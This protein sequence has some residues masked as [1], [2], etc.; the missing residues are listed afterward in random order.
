MKVGGRGQWRIERA[1][2]EAYIPQAY[3]ET[4]RELEKRDRT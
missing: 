3:D 2:L 1:E 4:A